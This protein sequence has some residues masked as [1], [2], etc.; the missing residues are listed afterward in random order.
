MDY[1][2]R[3]KDNGPDIFKMEV[4]T[5]AQSTFLEMARW[6]K[7]ISIFGFILMALGLIAGI[8]M[9]TFIANYSGVYPGGINTIVVMSVFYIV[10]IILYVYPTY[11][12]FKYS[13]LIKKS[14][15]TANTALFNSAVRY[16]K[17]MFKYLGILLV[18]SIILY[19]L[20]IIIAI[21][22]AA[23]RQAA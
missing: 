4:D 23:L 18:I 21:A 10:L 8:F 17:N 19:G 14:I 22:A 5:T 20:F 11:A 6:T 13:V 15:Q 7:F 16:L 2:D 9:S 3:N 12:L 1:F